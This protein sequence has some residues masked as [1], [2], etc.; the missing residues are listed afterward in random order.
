MK[1]SLITVCYNAEKTI[2]DAMASVASQR[3]G[4][5]DCSDCSDCP[6]DAVRESALKPVSELTVDDRRRIVGAI[7][8]T[9]VVDL[10][11]QSDERMKRFIRG[12]WDGDAKVI[13]EIIDWGGSVVP[14]RVENRYI[15]EIQTHK[16]AI[17]SILFHTRFRGPLKVLVLERLEDVLRDAVLYNKGKD[18]DETFY[19]LAHRL[20][21]DPC[22][23]NGIREFVAR[24]IVKETADGNR[25]WTIEFSNKKELTGVPTTG[26]AAT[27]EVTHLKPPSTHTIL[28]WVYAVNRVR[29]LEIEYIVVDGGSADGTVKEITNYELRIA[30]AKR[31]GFTFKWVSEKDRGMYDALN[32]GIRMAMGDVIGILNADDVLDGDETL[33]RVA[34][35]FQVQSSKFKV[36]ALYGNVRFVDELGGKTLRVCFARWWKPW[37]LQWG[38]MPPHPAIFIRK[39]CF[40]KW[41]GYEPDRKEYRIAADYELLIRF[42]RVHRMKARYM[43]V[44]TTVMRTGGVSTKDVEARKKLNEEIVKANRVNGYFCCFPMLL[45]KYFVKI[46]EFVV[47]RVRR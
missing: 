29:Q 43:P 25:T 13:R 38:Y 9:Q 40:E 34:H 21:F 2:A 22:D 32:K 6:I 4:L 27:V 31:C 16:N 35:E 23:G 24:L 17:R 41:G 46:W 5:F 33:A 47:P 18:G 19:N 8:A 36:Q 3:V 20:S 26:E 1:I 7:E 28:K 10:Q 42:F 15:G 30:N 39:E 12:Y 11:Q 37:M 45:P 14:K 44:C